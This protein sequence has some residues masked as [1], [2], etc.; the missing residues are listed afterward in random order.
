LLANFDSARFALLAILLITFVL[1]I[2]ER[3]RIDLIAVLIVVALAASRLL[4]S[5]E[6]LSGFG[7][8]PA[9]IVAAVFVLSGGLYRTGLS[10]RLGNWIA[11]IATKGYIGTL[12]V[13]MPS[14]AFLSAFTHHVTV[15]AVMLPVTLKM[16]RERGI[17]PSKL[18]MPLSFAASLG[19]TITI[20][21][22][23]AFLIADGVLRQSGRPGLGI[24]SIAPIGLALTLFGTLFTIIFGRF[25][26]PDSQGG[27]EA[28]EWSRLDGYYTELV[29]LPDS[30]FAQMTIKEIEQRDEHQLRVVNW[31]RKGRPQGRPFGN[32]QVEE[33]DVLLVQ[34]TPEE[35]A[36]VESE[37]GIA[38][39]PL[40]FQSEETPEANG[41]D[42]EES[43]RLVQA[44]VAPGS[45]LVGRTIDKVDL[46]KRFGVTAVGIWRQKGWVRTELARIRLREGDVLV[47]LGDREGFNRVARDQSFLM[48]VPF[49]G[50]AR[51]RYKGPLAAGIMLASILIVAFNFVPVEIGLL[52]GAAVMVLSGCLTARQAYQSIDVRIYVFIAG[53]I[54]LG[55][56]M[57]N[58]GASNYL[59]GLLKQVIGGWNPFLILF[60][61]FIFAGLITQVM[62]D[63][64]TTALLAPMALILAR[65]LGR[66]PE[67][68]VVT[69]AMASVASF[70]TPIGHHGN[71]LVYGP[72]RYKFTDFLRVGTPLTLVAAAIVVSLA[73]VLWP[74]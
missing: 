2:T 25:L 14:V 70:Y 64:A 69:V 11:R 71:L 27:D 19:T 37:P 47:L 46:P 33:G 43:E 39:N 40:R 12:G 6:A 49:K 17:S 1:L 5:E 34:T 51:L 59:A 8:A 73:Q 16:G 72:G 30:S 65:A 23:P 26:L 9:I 4:K 52:A 35:I 7:S 41:N 32:K 60:V 42:D 50:E 56:A 63:A 22:A 31:I 48:L 29:I 58:S 67:A 54:P 36:A 45:D 13:L 38:F 10:E 3:I 44:V 28:D 74:G 61:L 18:L 24:F 21:G 68:F 57:Q 62:S 55:L 66:A 20:I 15:T 53:A